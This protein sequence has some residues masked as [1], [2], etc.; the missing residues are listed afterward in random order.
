MKKI[1]HRPKILK[2]GS[3]G[4]TFEFPDTVELHTSQDNDTCIILIFSV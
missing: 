2:N 1:F 4:K 3:I